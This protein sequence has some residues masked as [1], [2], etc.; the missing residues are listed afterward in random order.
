MPANGLYALFDMDE[1]AVLII[2]N[3]HPNARR[4]LVFRQAP[5][6]DSKWG[7]RDFFL[8]PDDDASLVGTCYQGEDDEATEAFNT[9][10]IHAPGQPTSAFAGVAKQAVGLGYGATMYMGA[11]VAVDIL[12]DKAGVHSGSEL[13]SGHR[14]DSA[15]DLW[16]GLRKRKIAVRKTTEGGEDEEVDY[17]ETVEACFAE[18]DEYNGR[19]VRK[20]RGKCDD[21]EVC[22]TLVLGG[23]GEIDVDILFN[24][25]IRELP[26]ILEVSGQHDH[27]FTS[28]EEAAMVNILLPRAP[29]TDRLRIYV[30]WLSEKFGLAAAWAFAQRPDVAPYLGGGRSFSGLRGF[31][32]ASPGRVAALT[33]QGKKWA[34]IMKGLG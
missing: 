10:R 26:V 16:V 6:S 9:V 14:S 4:V 22:G 27:K 33:A 29:Q 32:G 13:S 20:A 21:V 23:G 11:A 17:C 18:P 30:E 12:L 15:D 2:Y 24:E 31:R 8:D 7:L 1:Q 3:G 25:K 28:P 19:P 5:D 34:E